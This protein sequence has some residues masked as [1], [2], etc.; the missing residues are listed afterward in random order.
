MKKIELEQLSS[1]YTVKRLQIEDT[2]LI[3]T[4][5]KSNPQYY[6]YCGKSLSVEEIESDLNIMPPGI[7][8]E[9]KY[10]IGFFENQKLIAV[11][12]LIDG[13][14]NSNVAFIGFF[15]MYGELQR[16]G[17]GSKIVSEALIY[18]KRQGFQTCQ[19]GI[20]KENPQS[21]HF[22]RKNGFQIIR[23]VVQ[24]EGIILVAEKQ[25]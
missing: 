14:P 18:L 21:N 8:M 1:T 20:D 24:E 22:W 10:Y 2:E 6:E 4:L 16:A 5:C 7:S 11:M 23:E 13:Y 12:D 17:I 19:L 3:Y 15:M 25:L 9:Q